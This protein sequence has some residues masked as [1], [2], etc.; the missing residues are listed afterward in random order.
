MPRMPRV[1]TFLPVPGDPGVAGL[2]GLPGRLR[3]T[4]GVRVPPGVRGWAARGH[5]RSVP[6]ALARE[7]ARRSDLFRLQ[8]G[9]GWPGVQ[10][11]PE[12]LH[13]RWIPGQRAGGAGRRAGRGLSSPRTLRPLTVLLIDPSIRRP[14]EEP[15]PAPERAVQGFSDAVA[16]GQRSR[17]H[18]ARAAARRGHR[19]PALESHHPGPPVQNCICARRLRIH[20]LP[21][22]RRPGF[23]GCRTG[24]RGVEAG[25]PGARSAR[26]LH[27]PLSA[28]PSTRRRR[29]GGL[30]GNRPGQGREHPGRARCRSPCPGRRSALPRRGASLG[31]GSRSPSSRAWV[32]RQAG[33]ASPCGRRWQPARSTSS[34]TSWFPLRST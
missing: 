4:T 26:P 3:G 31:R 17:E 23:G 19:L 29:A 9:A 18:R 1:R 15:P 8:R 11:L 5:P 2:G 27:R 12:Q 32:R 30:R 33:P 20:R 22:G 7:A 21:A 34:P 13:R 10:A 16:D 14:R 24:G 25:G 6:G 28:A